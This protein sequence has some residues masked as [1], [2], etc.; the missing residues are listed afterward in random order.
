MS[1]NNKCSGILRRSHKWKRSGG[2]DGAFYLSTNPRC[3]DCEGTEE[4]I[5]STFKEAYP[6]QDYNSVV[7]YINQKPKSEILEQTTKPE[8][9]NAE[10]IKEEEAPAF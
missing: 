5:K 9:E 7:I 10:E 6:S 1:Q 3:S 4:C 2:K 8:Q